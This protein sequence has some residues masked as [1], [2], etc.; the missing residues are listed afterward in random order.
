MDIQEISHSVVE[1]AE[2]ILPYV[3][4]TPLEHSMYLSNLTKANVYLKLESQ[5]KTG[6][7]K[8]RGAFNKLICCAKSQKEGTKYIT[9][10]TGN[11]G[12]ACAL[13]MTTLQL[14]GA[15]YIP[16]N[17]ST[18]KEN[19]LELYGVELRKHGLDCIETETMARA[20]AK[21]ENSIYISPY[22]DLEIMAGQGTVG[23]EISEDLPDVDAVFVTVGGGGLI[24]GIGSFL[25]SHQKRV[26]I[27]GCLPENSP[28]MYESV[29]AGHIVDIPSS[30]TLSDG[31]AGGIEEGSVTFP[32]CQKVVDRWVLVSESEISRAV[33]LM[34]EKHCKVIEGAA[35]VAVASFLK[36]SNEFCG[37]IVAV[38]LCGANISIA[39]LC[40]VIEDNKKNKT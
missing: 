37:K 34:L 7:F 22:A 25:K 15:V 26:E 35:G 21:S 23:K 3:Y 12:M 20:S 6:S 24:G 4:H 10:S 33:F 30:D 2:R 5:Q 1:A 32:V 13:A 16:E 31:S 27:I 28:V 17:A 8:V 40:Q 39:K 14:K 38:V 19:I 18:A 11:H 9:A 36:L 29:K